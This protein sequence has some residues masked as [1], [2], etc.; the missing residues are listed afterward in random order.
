MSFDFE[1]GPS[2]L[3]LALLRL[4]TMPVTFNLRFAAAVLIA[5]I[6]AFVPASRASAQY[7][8][9]NPASATAAPTSAPVKTVPTKPAAAAPP[10]GSIAT[11]YLIHPGDSLAIVVYGDATLS[12]TVTVLPDGSITYPLVGRVPVSNKT[13]AQAS[14]TLATSLKAYIKHP[15]VTISVATQG[16]LNVLVL[17]DVKTPG[18]YALRT[19]AFV[20]DAIAAAGGLDETNGDLPTARV[21]QQDGTIAQVSLQ[22]LLRGNPGASRNVTLADNAIVY[23]PGNEKLTVQVLGAVDRPGAIDLHDGDRLSMAIARA[24]TSPNIN[25]D[26]N[27]VVVTRT[28]EHG[29]ATSY[30]INMYKALKGGDLKMDPVL[31]KGDVVFVP[32]GYRANPNVFGPLELLRRLF[33][34]F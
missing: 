23:I 30:K 29:T 33:L 18:K 27:N 32:Q 14:D 16:Q 20:T 34:G 28:D 13:P 10:S 25:S 7:A 2:R 3:L 19:G 21:T 31:I 5:T 17:G 26:L 8:T 12:Q 9:P 11:N 15:L 24:G 6:A 1:L 4:R 22:S